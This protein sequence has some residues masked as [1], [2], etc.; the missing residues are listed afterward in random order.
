MKALNLQFQKSFLAE[1]F[2]LYYEILAYRNLM[3]CSVI[4]GKGM[5][6]VVTVKVFKNQYNLDTSNYYLVDN[7]SL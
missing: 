4:F 2:K 3:I 5:V 1:F 6:M 7:N